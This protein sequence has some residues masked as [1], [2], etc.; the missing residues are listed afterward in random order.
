LGES[1]CGS[2]SLGAGEGVEVGRGTVPYPGKD[3]EMNSPK[4]L[5]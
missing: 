4:V 2:D 1:C 5:V 3:A